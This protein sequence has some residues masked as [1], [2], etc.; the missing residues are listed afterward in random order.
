MN[1]L[2]CIILVFGLSLSSFAQDSNS[3]YK[4]SLKDVIEMAKE[5][6]PASLQVAT[7]KENK[8]WQWRTYRSNYS[9]QLSLSGT[10]PDFNRSFS[11]ITQPDGTTLFQPVEVA[12]SNIN[13]SLSQSIGLTGG[14]V[15]ASSGLNR[16]DNFDTDVT[17]WSGNPAI[18]GLQQPIFAFN[19]L[20]WDRKIEPLRYEESLREY[21]TE[22]EN[23]S[24]QAT[25]RFF[26]LL[27][28]QISLE[29]SKK[30]LANNDT[31]FQIAKGRYNLG[32]V[33]EN[34]LLQLELTLM[35]SRQAVAQSNLDLETSTLNL[36]SYIGFVENRAID[37]KIPGE[38]PT[39][40][41][42]E[43]KALEEANN[44]RKEVLSFQRRLI[45]ADML[46]AQA[47]GDNGLNLNLFG[48][49]G[50]TNRG[51]KASDIYSNPDDQQSLRLGFE[52]P[53]LD[54]GR[55]KSRIKTAEA[56]KKLVEYTV[57]QEKVNFSQEIYTQVK[58]FEMLKQQL[59]ITEK[60]DEIAQKRYDIS[61][62]RY[63]IGKIGITDLNIALQEKDV[64][65][66]TYISS[67]RNF[68]SAYYKLRFLTLYDFE[69]DTSLISATSE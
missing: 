41:V 38:I 65:K 64:A 52:I 58:Q 48:T 4:L 63:F 30:N 31:I 44:N 32:K 61:K 35:N 1:K 67:L 14:R 20:A 28:A 10:L 5:Q 42:N 8:Y 24:E 68:W 12:N 27:L 49:F 39:F 59:K 33:A 3:G 7:I 11:P 57:N 47:R 45:E 36:K 18:I 26:D 69:N 55:S 22:L 50:F 25:Q 60:A 21:V 51:D 54:W 15:F 29:I 37:L 6:S 43:D 16:F 66:R 9:P 23:I 17:R 46:V 40:V 19:E 2:L 53:V 13:L 34:E 62:N 56:N